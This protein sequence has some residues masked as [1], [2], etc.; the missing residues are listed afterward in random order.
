MEVHRLSQTV[1]LGQHRGEGVIL[2]LQ[3]RVAAGE[4]VLAVDRGVVFRIGD[5]AESVAQLGL[6]VVSRHLGVGQPGRALNV[7]HGHVGII[8][9]PCLIP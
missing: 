6:E 5:P 1:R 8:V 2:P 9:L 4:A 7:P 3:G